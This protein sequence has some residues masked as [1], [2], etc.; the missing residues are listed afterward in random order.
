M[1]QPVVHM[2]DH[3]GFPVR[4]LTR[5]KQKGETLFGKHFDI[6]QGDIHDKDSLVKAMNGC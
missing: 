2:L 1:G 6:V 3:F 4:V 5:D